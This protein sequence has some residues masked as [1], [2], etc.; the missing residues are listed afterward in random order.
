MTRLPICVFIFSLFILDV[1]NGFAFRFEGLYKLDII[2]YNDFHARFEE[3]SV[4]TPTCRTNNSHCLGGFPRLYYEVNKLFKEKPDAL[5]LNAGDSFQGTY[6]YTLLK[7]N[8]TQE[9]MNMMKHDAHAIGNHEFD[10]GP[11]GLAPYLS[12]LKAP[13]LAA[14]MDVS[15][16]P[17]LQGLFLNHTV[18]ERNHRK[19]GVIGLITQDTKELS[20]AGDVVFTDPGEALKREAELL[21]EKGVDIIIL[22]SHCGLKIDQDLARDYGQYVD[23]IIGGH[24][25]SLLWN[26]PP[27]SKETVAGP[28]P[29]FVQNSADDKQVLIVQASAFTKYMGNLTVYFDYKGDYVKWEGGPIFLDRSIPEDEEIKARLAPYAARVHEAYNIP[30]GETLTNLPFEEC[31]YG[32]CAIGDLLV[33]ALVDLAKSKTRGDRDHLAFIQRGNIKSSFP[34]GTITKGELFE[35]LP[36]KDRIQTFDLLGRFVL[37]ALERSVKDAWAYDPFKGP[38]VLQISGLQVTYNV[39]NP[40]GHRL[41]SVFVGGPGS[42]RLLEAEEYYQVTVPAYLGDGG[43]GFKMFKEGRRNMRVIG[44]DQEAVEAYIKEHSPLNVTTDGR[45]KIFQ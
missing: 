8:I 13:V 23:I 10:D 40:E 39:S 38:W 45:I 31:V 27:P 22:L 18:V 42:T 32:E 17:I 33:D 43:D 25:H 15:R 3:T 11:E 37:E 12:H 1:V 44:R 9:F 19:I 21:N 16:V 6:W 4:E 20:S 5:L 36:Y 24:T 7:W 26:G 28:Y 29:V 35:L 14:N 2:H 30:I 34:E 41:T